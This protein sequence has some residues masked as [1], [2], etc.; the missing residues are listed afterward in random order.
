MT[1]KADEE[2]QAL[3]TRLYC[4]EDVSAEIVKNLR[5]RGFDVLCARDAGL[6]SRDDDAQL[7]FAA[8]QGRALVTHNRHDFEVR[9][10]NYVEAGQRHWGVIIAKRR[11]RPAHVVR[12]LLSLLNRVAAEE[13]QDQ[14][15]YI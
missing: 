8:S 12:R 14:L 6:L 1:E 15:W 5:Q 3:Y 7:A 4:D 10:Q 11:S 13:M 9:H 2:L